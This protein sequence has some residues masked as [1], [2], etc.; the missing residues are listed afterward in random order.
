MVYSSHIHSWRSPLGRPH[1]GSLIELELKLDGS[2]KFRVWGLGFR[3]WG[4]GF[5]YATPYLEV[6][7]AYVGY[8]KYK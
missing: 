7:G 6:H 8:P 3:L 1:F 5:S 4:L 2:I